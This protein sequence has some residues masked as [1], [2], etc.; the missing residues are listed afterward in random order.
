MNL[1]L[2]FGDWFTLRELCKTNHRRFDN[3]PTAEAI[4]NL[5]RLVALALN[6]LRQQFGALWIESG[7]RSLQVN[8]AVGGQ[9]ASA[10]LE[11]RAAD[12][13]PLRPEIT[14]DMMMAFLRDSDVPFD[15]AIAEHSCHG[16]WL[17]IAVARTGCD[18]RR[19]LLHK[20]FGGNFEIW[21]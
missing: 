5:S 18:G 19:Q 15:Q 2:N 12:T 7:F 14:I 10:H 4:T 11:G 3:T 20:P 6:P 9:P 8:A 13:V 16:Q 21:R 1:D 17:H